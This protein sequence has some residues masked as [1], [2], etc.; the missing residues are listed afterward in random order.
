[1]SATLL[2]GAGA[3]LT[4]VRARRTKTD[5]AE[6]KDAKSLRPVYISMGT[7]AQA[8]G[9]AYIEVGNCKILCSV[10]GPRPDAASAPFSTT[11]RIACT[12][13]FADFAGV[14]ESEIER[15]EAQVQMAVRPAL[16]CAVLLEKYPKSV[17]D[18]QL[19][20]L[21]AAGDVEAPCIT[22]GALALA[23]AG[24]EMLDL[25][26]AVAVARH[27]GSGKL[28]ID[29]AQPGWEIGGGSLLLASM[30]L[31]NEITQLSQVGG[32]GGG[33][34]WAVE[35][36][37]EAMFLALEGCRQLHTLMRAALVEASTAPGKDVAESSDA[38]MKE[39]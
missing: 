24:V 18:V 28:E 25:V 23:H 2:Q 37:E 38:A 12:V 16:E 3:R 19:L 34:D 33:Q 26:A 39:G 35:L 7:V 27:P 9:S 20:V 4:R 13:N 32:R 6:E 11:G 22:C 36:F 5:G 8:P 1:M 31:R 14:A 30:P 10:H 15:E 21:E 29:P 17:L